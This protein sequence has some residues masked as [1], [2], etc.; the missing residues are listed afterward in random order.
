MGNTF[1]VHNATIIAQ[2]A[3]AQLRKNMV[4]VKRVRRDFDSEVATYGSAVKIPKFAA[5]SANTKTGGSNVTV[6]D[7][8]SDSVTV[9]LNQHKEATFIIEDIEKALSRNDLLAGY[10]AGAITAIT[11]KVETTLLGLYANLTQ[12]VGSYATA[13]T[14]ANILTARKYLEAAGAPRNDRTLVLSNK[15]IEALLQADT[16]FLASYN[17]KGDAQ[18]LAEGIVGKLWGFDVMESNMLALHDSNQMSN[19]AFHKDAFALVCRPLPTDFPSNMG[20]VAAV[21]QDPDS[22]LAVRVILTYN[23]SRLGVQCT[24]DVLFGV[25]EMRDELAVEVKG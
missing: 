4:M 9:T 7:L 6:Q 17:S 22:G 1:T 12:T 2:E 21:A 13:P 3:L 25:A 18:A 15:D 14:K 8:T 20:V 24:V 16:Y 19:L 11:E 23:P 5:L 10:M